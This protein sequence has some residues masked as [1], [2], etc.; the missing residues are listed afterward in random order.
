MNKFSASIAVLVSFL[1]PLSLGAQTTWTSPTQVPPNGN[2]DSPIH[3]G[4]SAQIKTGGLSVGSFISN[5]ITYL[6]GSTT[7]GNGY[8][9]PRQL[10]SIGSYLDIYSGAANNPSAASIRASSAG[11]LVLNGSLAGNVYLNFDTGASTYIM[12]SGNTGIGTTNPTMKGTGVPKLHVF[13][14]TGNNLALVV[15]NAATGVND[16]ATLQLKTGSSGNY[17]QWFTRGGDLYAGVANIA[18]YFVIKDGGAVGIGVSAPAAKLDVAGT[19]KATGLQITGGSP[20]SGKVLT[21]DASGN[22]TWQTATGG[23]TEVDTLQTVT[24]RGNSTTQSVTTGGLTVT[25][26]ALV[27]TSAGTAMVTGRQVGST[28]AYNDAIFKAITDNPSGASNYYIQGVTGGV[29]GT[30]NFSVRADGQA[31]F[32]GNTGVGVSSPT[33]KLDVAGTVKATGLQITGGSPASG[34]VL[35]S[36]ASGNATWQSVA[37]GSS[38]TVTSVAAGTGLTGGTITTTGTIAADTNYL[39]RRVSSS[40]AAGSS[41]RAIAADGTVTC[42]T[43]SGITA[44]T[45]TLDSVAGRGNTTTKTIVVGRVTLGG[46]TNG[47]LMYDPNGDGSFWLKVGGKYLSFDATGDLTVNNGGVS[48]AS[49]GTL[50][51]GS[52]ARQMVN[53]YST[54]YGIGV[55]SNTE[56]FRTN[57]AYAWYK[58]GSHSSTQ[59]DPGS[60]GSVLMK[61]SS[62][63][64]LTTTGSTY[65]TAFYYS[66]DKNLKQ[67]IEKLDPQTSLAKVLSLQGVSFD[68]KKDGTHSVGLIAQDVEKV[69]PELV[70]T[71]ASSGLKSVEYGNLV[72][73]LIEAV[74]AQQKQIDSLKAEIELMKATR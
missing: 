42:E 23:G 36:D 52:A 39:Q 32:A 29:G 14:N 43:D 71:D 4:S 11:N 16:G 17:W 19:V 3:T 13:G 51:L 59:W 7:I 26:A 47:A 48:I 66:S 53:L 33:Q 72:A 50:S 70:H 40:C 37:G 20:A 45:D 41:I 22:A 63:G 74:K 69:Y 28:Y 34:K 5:G 31:Y 68:W 56:Y 67:N 25:G 64:D 38:G 58:G 35:T 49:A 8:S 62:A 12:G 61:L 24:N 46:T 18:D 27:G 55:Q 44:E 57:S 30:T 2:V 54:T 73:P 10:L 15:E 21:S 65:S 60:G 1:L 6:T 9:L